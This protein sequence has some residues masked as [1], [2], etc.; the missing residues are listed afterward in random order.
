MRL[1]SLRILGA[2]EIG[3]LGG[4]DAASWC[5]ALHGPASKKMNNLPINGDPAADDGDGKCF[6]MLKL[7]A[8]FPSCAGG[9][10][11]CSA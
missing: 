1:Q 9:V 10:P 4:T 5:N 8:D 6:I 11:T 7:L 2:P 3:Q